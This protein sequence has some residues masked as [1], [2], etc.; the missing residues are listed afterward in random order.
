MDV[1]GLKIKHVSNPRIEDV[2]LP[3]FT[4]VAIA[5]GISRYCKSYFL[6]EDSFVK[7]AR[8][9]KGLKFW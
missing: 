4:Y 2:A 3:A 9:Q 8:K 6:L 5:V 1:H 7:Q